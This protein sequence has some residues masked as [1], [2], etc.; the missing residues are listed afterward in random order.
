MNNLEVGK[1]GYYGDYDFARLRPTIAARGVCLECGKQYEPFTAKSYFVNAYTWS[2]H[3]TGI[4]QT[5]TSYSGICPECFA[6]IKK[7][8]YHLPRA[9]AQFRVA[10]H[11]HGIDKDGRDVIFEIM[12]EIEK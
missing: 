8:E 7:W 5:V 4:Y 6:H 12:T 2:G 1:R 10:D 11:Q 3:H 9:D